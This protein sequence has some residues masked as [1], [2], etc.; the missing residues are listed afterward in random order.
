MSTE[1]QRSCLEKAEAQR[2]IAFSL[3]HQAKQLMQRGNHAERMAEYWEKRALE[4][5]FPEVVTTPPSEQITSQQT[6][7][8]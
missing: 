5:P 4:D 7:S 3:R 1:H 8:W 6:P 2:E